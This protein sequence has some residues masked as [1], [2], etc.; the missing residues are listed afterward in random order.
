VMMI[1]VKAEF[2]KS[3]QHQPKIS[4]RRAGGISNG[5]TVR[6]LTGGQT[7]VPSAPRQAR[8]GPARLIPI[9]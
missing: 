4:R 5:D 3:K 1:V 8:P 6:T 2:A 9:G 7:I